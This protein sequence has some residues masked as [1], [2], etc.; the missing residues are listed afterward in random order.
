MKTKRL[1][2]LFMVVCFIT[3]MIPA[4]PVAA[5]NGER[6]DS[7]AASNP[8]A[9]DSAAEGLEA[10]S[11]GAGG[12]SAADMMNITAAP[13]AIEY[14]RLSPEVPILNAYTGNSAKYYE[15][16]IGDGS[17]YNAVGLFGIKSSSR[18]SNK[19]YF[20]DGFYNSVL[21]K[22]AGTRDNL[23]VNASGT[24]HNNWHT[25]SWGFLGYYSQKV[26][27]FSGLTLAA[28]GEPLR[29]NGSQRSNE[30]NARIGNGEF[31]TVPYSSYD[32]FPGSTHLKEIKLNFTQ[33]NVKYDSGKKQCDCG[34]HY[35]EKTV[36]AFKDERAPKV[37]YLGGTYR[38]Q[39]SF[40]AGD[41]ITVNIQYDEPIRFADDSD[42][43]DDLYV[44]L[45]IS[46][47]TVDQQPK[48]MLTK[49]DNDT[50]YFSYIVK[51]EDGV[52]TITGI[53]LSP[54]MG[55]DL[56]LKQVGKVAPRGGVDM[57]FNVF[58]PSDVG[59]N[60][61]GFTTTTS[62][63]TDLAG[64]AITEKYLPYVYG[65]GIDTEKPYVQKINTRLYPNNNDVKEALEKT[66]PKA[67]DY[68]DESDTHLGKGDSVVVE[69]VMNEKL[70]LTPSSVS[71][72]MDYFG[73]TRHGFY[74]SVFA[75]TNLQNSSG[76][77]IKLASN[78][79]YR[80]LPYGEQNGDAQSGDKVTYI[81][82]EDLKIESNTTCTDAD[83]QLRITGISFEGAY[84]QTLK[85]FAGNEI[86]YTDFTDKNI[87]MSECIIDTTQPEV[88]TSASFSKIGEDTIYKVEKVSGQDERAFRFPL[89]TSDASGVNQLTGG[90]VWSMGGQ[91]AP[92][93]YLVTP[94][95]LLGANE[96]WKTGNMGTV[97][98]FT[99][100]EG[101]QYI[102]IRPVAGE[103]YGVYD[104]ELRFNATDYAGNGNLNQA[105]P[106]RSFK[107]DAFWDDLKPTAS[108][109]KVSRS[110]DA[111]GGGATM[112]VEILLEEQS[113]LDEAY[114][115]WND[116]ADPADD[117]EDWKAAPGE[118][119]DKRE[120]NVTAGVMVEKGA[121]FSKN[122]WVKVSDTTGNVLIKNLGVF[123]YNLEE[124]SYALDYS[125]AIKH[126]ASVIVQD[127]Q[128]DSTL[129]FMVKDPTG[130]SNYYVRVFSHEAADESNE[131]KRELFGAD[132]DPAYDPDLQYVSL[133]SKMKVEETNGQYTFIELTYD[134]GNPDDPDN[135]YDYDY[136]DSIRGASDYPL[137][138]FSGE[139]A[140]T[141]LAGL[142]DAFE[143]KTFNPT[144]GVTHLEYPLTAGVIGY[145]V[146][147]ESIVLRISSA[148]DSSAD[149]FT[150]MSL[151]TGQTINNRNSFSEYWKKGDPTVLATAEGIAFAVN[152]G[153]DVHGWNYEDI[154]YAKSYIGLINNIDSSVTYKTH[155]SSSPQQTVV[156]PKG[157]YAYGDYTIRLHAACK[158]GKDYDIDLTDMMYIDPAP[159]CRDFGVTTM[160]YAPYMGRDEYYCHALNDTANGYTDEEVTYVDDKTNYYS[161]AEVIYLPVHRNT[162][163]EQPNVMMVEF[164]GEAATNYAVRAW[165]VTAGVEPEE[166]DYSIPYS[167]YE[168][169]E[170]TPAPIN[171]RAFYLTVWDDADQVKDEK[172]DVYGQDYSYLTQLG[173]IRNQ[174]NTIAVQVL[175]SNGKVSDIGYY[176]VHPVDY[177]VRGQVTATRGVDGSNVVSRGNLIFTSD[178]EQLMDGVRVYAT[179]WSAEGSKK[180][181]TQEMVLQADG[182]YICPLVPGKYTYYV[183]CIDQYGNISLLGL[184]H[185][186]LIAQAGLADAVV[187]QQAPFVSEIEGRKSTNNGIYEAVFKVEDDTLSAYAPDKSGKP[188]VY[189][190]MKVNLYFDAAHSEWLG[191]PENM[192][193]ELTLNKAESEY[194]WKA[195][196]SSLTGIY[197]VMA[198]RKS[199][200]DPDNPSYWLEVTVKGAVGYKDEAGPQS[201]T[202][203]MDAT[204]ALGNSY[205][206]ETGIA[207][208]GAANVKPAADIS[209]ENAPA[210]NNIGSSFDRALTIQF[211][212]P[213]LPEASWICPQPQYGTVQTDAFPIFD[214]GEWEITFYDVFGRKYSQSLELNN[215]FNEYGLSLMI[216]PLTLTGDDADFAVR[217]LEGDT[218]GALLLF[219]KV[220]SSIETV[221]NE[222]GTHN[223]PLKEKQTTLTDNVTLVVYHYDQVYTHDELFGHQS[224][225]TQGDKLEIHI[226]NIG[227]AAP[228]AVPHFYFEANGTEYTEDTLP[229]DTPSGGTTTDGNVR[230]WYTTSRNV[231]PT[232]DTGAEFTFKYDGS[233]SHTFKYIDDLGNEGS[234]TVNLS[235]LGIS[236]AAPPEP[237]E[238]W[239]D[240]N[241]PVVNV[242]VWAK[243]S[244]VYNAADSFGSNTETIITAAFEAVSY[245]QGYILRVN[246]SDESSYKIVLLKD[247]P[248]TLTYAGANSESIVGASLSG[249]TIIITED[250]TTDFYIAVVDNA[251]GESGATADNYVY[252][253]I[254]AS[255]MTDWFDTTPPT[256]KTHYLSKSLYERVAY[257]KLTDTANND[258]NTGAVILDSP[259]LEIETAASG[260]QAE[261]NGWYKRAFT[262][263]TV[264]HLV[265]YDIAG[266][267]STADIGVSNLDDEKPELTTVWS[268][269]HTSDDADDPENP[270]VVNRNGPPAGPLNT[271]VTAVISSSK[272]IKSVTA[273]Y[274]SDNENWESNPDSDTVKALMNKVKFTYSPDYVTVKFDGDK[275][276]IRLTVTASNGRSTVESLFLTKGV[277]D[278]IP[279]TIVKAVEYQKRT[280]YTMPYAAK[281]TLSP[282]EDSYCL[283]AGKAGTL[284]SDS[285]P[286]ILATSTNGDTTY[287]FADKAGNRREVTVTTADID[288]TAPQLTTE[289]DNTSD[290]TTTSGS[291]TVDIKVNEACKVV[292]GTNIYELAADGTQTLTF[293]NNG[294]YLI[295]AYD[296]A[297][298]STSKTVVIGNIDKTAPVIS[299]DQ[300]T[301]SLR[302]DSLS[303]ALTPLLEDGV[304]VWDNIDKE[305]EL[306]PALNYDT[307]AVKLDTPGIYS[308]PYTVTDSA[309]NVGTNT[310]F[311]K[312]I[313]KNLPSIVI[314]DKITEADGT[315][316]I[317]TGEHQLRV[318]GLKTIAPNE[319]EPYTLKIRRGICTDAQMKYFSSTVL[320]DGDGKFT[321]NTEGFYTLYI[322]T[323]SRQSY[324]TL[325]YVER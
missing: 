241:P 154:D 303:T 95:A 30:T 13:G 46:G 23:Q 255:D 321:I 222:E 181:E 93:E 294:V 251:S 172:G 28:K 148:S 16:L 324:R 295:T 273:E 325:L 67:G 4:L 89:T 42:K 192:S 314:D 170:W 24:F 159:E 14:K 39:G 79:A 313:D 277:I 259:K 140:V 233:S 167:Y 262:T 187:D 250:L 289:P 281:I 156:F 214:D 310:R 53:D 186:L 118:I 169:T 116:G 196:Q 82:F 7:S 126:K 166:A 157:D 258:A 17:F 191:I 40:K 269:P 304:N 111:G 72:N 149:A 216:N 138:I 308:V 125:P 217:T 195:T 145:P 246:A 85:D 90:F 83:G 185:P 276:G 124:A 63:I 60:T 87:S 49:L 10:A 299:F 104:T 260:A 292:C 130:D 218:D 110:L 50:L 176:T 173:L 300:T 97:C 54:L 245:V 190:P 261:Y 121:H 302:Q 203:Y 129:V 100:V 141:V 319:M 204:D 15:T 76:N 165:N 278:I 106:T 158:A 107:L 132:D 36:V 99:Q 312:V 232:D 219:K 242:D 171:K 123:E 3:A 253:A 11:A 86:A 215:V 133:W 285:N 182:S 143:V 280:D 163:G 114:Y 155:L 211:N 115:L 199:D 69:L 286:L 29:L 47:R 208:A 71:P 22:V 243:R 44:R 2:A 212:Q 59:G 102:Y 144:A 77:P 252:F 74:N 306:K 152:L 183:Y 34:G 101:Q 73:D 320:V 142:D 32:D 194:V 307:S 282:D 84:R 150:G 180:E 119:K 228:E 18:I 5:S 52:Q 151:T 209:G 112:D 61:L 37:Y 188:K 25:H 66:D 137:P 293:D 68:Y 231:T 227:K 108:P 240:E 41:E 268:P 135:P 160:S 178:G 237:E 88:N 296:G 225:H 284:Y 201:F 287:T 113:L 267:Q 174:N 206:D 279:P 26:L 168:G 193:L 265:F 120:G 189:M 224:R 96:D 109:G 94:R 207:F 311:V 117:D 146:T 162:D 21:Y 81:V 136:L 301:F 19:T 297:G 322:I 51:P 226:T 75:L 58:L 134:P 43:H 91:T 291:V 179:V 45:A 62:Y 105:V 139:L 147:A 248:S 220:G 210:Y 290:L 257:I 9:M 27:A 288:R 103:S 128:E 316:A 230:V 92:F 65:A 164:D 8:D 221:Q 64:N 57:S 298:N 200:E 309:G 229:R 78:G 238:P 264:D 6:G 131:V 305:S 161:D 55:D 177:E 266:N 122:L 247:E 197:E 272:S 127:M 270:P 202:L 20:Y 48:A 239:K 254:K 98:S 234:L 323:Q 80:D 317:T 315:M 318:E 249:N 223:K 56:P 235:D 175:N 35:V 274:S 271:V 244:G 283:N 213:V 1:L 12:L 33:S 184:Q 275:V 205:N 263:N 70:N 236:L 198:Q 153:E 38:T 256:A 31:I